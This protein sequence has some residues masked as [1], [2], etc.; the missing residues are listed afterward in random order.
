MPLKTAEEDQKEE[1]ATARVVSAEETSIGTEV[2]AV[3]TEQDVI[4]PIKEEQRTALKAFEV[5]FWKEFS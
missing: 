4:F 5:R 1:E 2:A 3:L